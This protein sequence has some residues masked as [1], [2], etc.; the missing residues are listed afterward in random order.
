MVAGV[1]GLAKMIMYKTVYISEFNLSFEHGGGL[2]CY[3]IM[4]NSLFNFDRYYSLHFTEKDASLM[5]EIA[6]KN[7]NISPIFPYPD[8]PVELNFEYL[9]FKSKQLLNRAFSIKFNNFEDYH[10]FSQKVCNYF[11]QEAIDCNTKILVIPQ[12]N[13]STDIVN[14]LYDKHQI[15][16]IVWMMDDHLLKFKNGRWIYPRGYEKKFK[17]L[18]T[19]AYQVITISPQMAD[20]YKK[21]FSVNSTI[22]FSGVDFQNFISYPSQLDS[23]KTTLAYLGSI[24]SWQTDAI[25]M[26]FPLLDTNKVEIHIYSHQNLPASLIR[27]GIFYKGALNHDELKTVIKFYDGIL[28]PNSFDSKYRNMVEFNIAT[29]MTEAIAS[30]TVP[31]VIAPE[32]SAMSNFVKSRNLGIVVDS[33]EKITLL[34]DLKNDSKRKFW[35]CNNEKCYNNE[36]SKDAMQNKWELIWDKFIK[37]L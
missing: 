20:F 32:Y 10:I 6:S 8:F 19:N 14:S 34:D 30:G 25:S 22:I 11:T 18:L 33:E 9:K 17:K 1:G 12:G 7:T 27:H 15:K 26:L 31:V 23:E 36:I 35:L 2:T 29:K 4:G 24:H 13:L 37:E 21:R 16:Y 28:L 5:Q 3:R